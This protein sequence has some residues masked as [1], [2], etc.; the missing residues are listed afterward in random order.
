[1]PITVSCDWCGGQPAYNYPAGSGP[2]Y[3]CQGCHS[4]KNKPYNDRQ[5]LHMIV[6]QTEV[7][8]KHIAPVVEAQKSLQKAKRDLQQA[9]AMVAAVYKGDEA[10][11]DYDRMLYRHNDRHQTEYHAECLACQ[12]LRELGVAQ[13][14]GT[15]S[16]GEPEAKKRLKEGAA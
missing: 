5:R 12:A 1:M 9:E 11:R 7:Y 2:P 13:D 8:C 15:H 6:A 10:G 14:I 3:L 16:E 4:K